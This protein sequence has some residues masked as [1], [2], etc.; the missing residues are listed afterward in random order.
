MSS[1]SDNALATCTIC[2]EVYHQDKCSTTVLPCKHIFCR[3]CIHTWIL[4]LYLSAQDNSH[5]PAPTCPMCRG[6]IRLIEN[7]GPR[8]VISL[9]PLSTYP[10]SNSERVN[11]LLDQASLFDGP[12]IGLFDHAL[13]QAPRVPSQIFMSGQQYMNVE[14]DLEVRIRMRVLEQLCIGT[15]FSPTS[16]IF[17]GVARAV[18]FS[19]ALDRREA[20]NSDQDA[21]MQPSGDSST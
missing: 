5:P 3:V 4:Q 10:R 1:N 21:A 8:E 11:W 12:A 17:P 9:K 14:T 13:A 20:R 16:G 6:T 2:R 7:T 18:N 15:E 19:T